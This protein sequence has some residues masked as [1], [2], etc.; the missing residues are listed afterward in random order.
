MTGRHSR[1]APHPL[2]DRVHGWWAS[3][4]DGARRTAVG[5]LL[6]LIGAALVVEVLAGQ[7]NVV[8]CLALS[9]V[10]WGEGFACAHRSY[11]EYGWAQVTAAFAV[12]MLIPVCVDLVLSLFLGFS[13]GD[14]LFVALLLVPPFLGL[15]TV[16]SRT[17]WRL[18]ER[19]R[20]SAIRSRVSLAVRERYVSIMSPTWEAERAAEHARVLAERD[21][22]TEAWLHVGLPV[23]RRLALIAAGIDPG[24]AFDA[25]VIAL[26]DDDLETLAGMLRYS[27]GEVD[28]FALLAD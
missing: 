13:P 7:W 22:L 11:Y 12:M 20:Y 27:A 15:A 17:G 18:A 23:R 21:R 1:V 2:V 9:A 4:P 28:P 14:R 24:H 5:A 25:D 26:D 10:V 19:G 8:L 3:L 16:M 6:V